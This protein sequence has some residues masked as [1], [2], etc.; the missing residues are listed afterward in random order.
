MVD[1]NSGLWTYTLND[2]AQVLAQGQTATETFEVSVADQSGA[3]ASKTVTVSLTGTNDAP[4]ITLASVLDGV[5]VEHSSVTASGQIGANDI[6]NGA[7]LTFGVGD[8]GGLSEVG[9][10]G[11]LVIDPVTGVWTYT[12]DDSVHSLAQDETEFESF[13]VAV[14][15]EF[16]AS[17]AATVTII[18]TGSNDAPVITSA[19]QAGAVQEDVQPLATGQVTASDVDLGATLAYSGDAT[20]VYGSF[21]IDATSGQWSYALD[22]AAHQNLAAG[23]TH[24]ETFTVT[25]TDEHGAT[26]AQDVTITV[27]GSNDA[28]VVTSATQAGAVQEDV[29]PLATGQV[30]ASD[31]DLGATLAYSGDATGVYG[32]FAIDATSGQWSYALDSAA[33]Q[34]L[35]AGE[36]HAETFTV[37]VTDEHGATAA[38]DVTITVTGSNDAPVVTSATQAG[39]V[40]ED[41][42][43]LATGQVTASDVDLGATLA[44]SG[45]A[46][47]VY[48]SF[49]IDATSGQWSYALDSAAHQNLAAGET[50][51]ETFTVTVT[52]EHGAT[53]AQD[54]TITVTGSNDAPVVTSATQAGA[55]QEDVQPLATGQVTAS[56]VDLGATLAYSGDATGVYGSFAIDATSG[57]WSYALDSAAHQNLAAGETHAE[58]FTVTVTDEH[59]ATAAQDVT[60][61]VTGSNDAPVVTSATQAGAVQE[62]VQPLATG[63]VTASDVDLGATLAYSGDATGVYGSFAIDATSGQWSYAL[64]SAAHQNL[65]AGE[66]HAETFTVTVTDEHGA[67]AA[68]DVTITVTGSN[69]A[70]VVTSATQA[71]AVQEDVQPLATGQVTASDVDLGATLA[72][73][74]DATGV[75]GS[76]AI[77]ATSGQWSYALDSAA[78]Q[79]L[80]AGETHAETFTVTV[81]DEHGATAAQDVT[82]TVTG[83]NDAPVVT[84]ATQ[85][86]AVQEDVQPL[87][88]GQVT[89]SDVDLGATLAY[90]GDAIG[91]YGSFAIDATSGQWSYALDSAAHQNLAAGE[92]HAETFTVTV[93]D[94]HGATAA[95]DVTITVT[96]SNDAP[97]VTSATQAGA[98]QEDVQPLATGQVTAS[99]VDLGAT[100][101]YSGDATGVYGSF[102]IDATSGQWSYALD[103]AAHQNL[104]AGETH[105]ETFTV[106]VTD[107]HGA[108]AAQDV[109]ITVTGSNDAPVVSGPVTGTAAEEGAPSTLDA[110][111]HASDI[112]DG[113]ILSVTG[114]PDTLPAGVTFDAATHS[115]TLDPSDPAYLHLANG[116]TIGVSVS[117]AVSD[118]ITATPASVSWTVT[119]VNH[120]PVVAGTV[121]GTAIEDGVPST[122]NALAN[123]TD[124]DSG[125]TLLVTDVPGTLPAG[126]SYDAALQTFTLDPS[127]LAFQHL[128]AGASTVVSVNYTVSDG[129]AATPASMSWTVTGSNDAPVV[130]SATQ[131]GAV[132]EDV[133]PLATGQVTA[134]DVDLGATLAYSGDATGVY[135]SFAIDATSGQWSYALDSAAHQNLAAGETHAETFTVTVTDEHGATAA[136]D[137]TIT[138]TGSNDAPVVTSAT[139]AGAVQEDVQPLATGQVTASDVDLGATLAYSGDATGVYGSFAIDATSG[140]W[141]YALDSA[142]HQNLAAGETHAETFTVTVTDEHGATAAQDVTITVTGSNDA[143]V[144]S[145]PVTGTA[146]EEG[147]PSTL[148]ALAHASDIDDGTILSVTGLPDTLPAGVTFDAATHSFT[149]D[150]SDPAYL[151]LANGATI[152]VSVSYAV[153]DGI[154]ATPA[155]VSWTV[156]SVNHVPVVAGTVIGTAIEDGVPS[157]LNALANATDADS[158]TTL[159]VT[160]VPG[161]LPAGVSYDAA[162]QTFTLDP[163]NL[164]F[165]H[166]AAGAS[167][168]VSVNYTV[169]DGIAATPASMSWTVTGSNDA[170]VVTSATQAGAVQ[171]DVQPAAPPDR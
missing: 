121:I 98:V 120:V 100:L 5:V 16:G 89:A 156:T 136:Q 161:T 90:S 45:D 48:G 118:G 24:A 7:V 153:S 31:V 58:T 119:S 102:A 148:D 135:G 142:A 10:F 61:T 18:V 141:S 150:P 133:Q 28:P 55:V 70:P 74:G 59:G 116:A 25:V 54:V 94:E 37:T 39:A 163:S 92:T 137:V 159:L 78:H 122:L 146:A 147:A 50:H 82:I 95:Q 162:L 113:T 144:V 23:E 52:D 14:T 69:D 171:E 1:P 166:L 68:Q 157:T 91:V 139:Q 21:A 145:G 128:A 86:G 155:S 81:T 67:T 127:N 53:A 129:I 33:H 66:T 140:Q 17:A 73:S 99:D 152:G 32:S 27:T 108:T 112:D 130:T 168:V 43:P 64:D 22:S 2:Q 109:T 83:S 40:Q 56:D 132:Q 134:S 170:P 8:A 38:Q 60:I 165:Q 111:A 4:E 49:A 160:D 151:H 26:A 149:L 169:S 80:A 114:L 79:N 104:A 36:T 13:R 41:V 42:Q 51:A 110:L 35:A 125:T 63:Q 29:Q 30:T 72:Y 131:A 71:G 76:F 44:Y 143:P 6:D 57:Q 11:T 19:T 154:T 126:V 20:G 115:F 62:D 34:N 15:D 84:S 87:A 77:D 138:V 106:T 124:A 105:A 65:A 123:A 164:A 88:T 46:T 96:G 158:G 85:A 75:Y 167:T 3:T 93:T 97:V 47:G 107:E 101:A 9:T 117:Y 103:S 12:L